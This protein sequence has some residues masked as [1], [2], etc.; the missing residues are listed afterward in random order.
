MDYS[1]TPEHVSH[2]TRRVSLSTNSF[3]ES[4]R[5]QQVLIIGFDTEYQVGEELHNQVLSYQYSAEIL[6]SDQTLEGE[7]WEGIVIPKST[8]L[9]DRLS[10]PEFLS[11]IFSEGISDFPDIVIP[12]NVYLVAHFTRADIPAFSEFNDDRQRRTLNL[13]NIRNSFV[14]MSKTVRVDL[15]DTNDQSPITINVM[16]RDSLHLSP[17]SHKSL[18]SVG[19]ILGIEKIVLSEDPHQNQQIKENMIDLFGR[20]WNLFR[21]YA[22]TD[23]VIC[24]QYT[25]KMIRLYQDRTGK[26]KLPLTL[27]SIGVDLLIK[28]WEDQGIDPL[29]ILGK[30]KHKQ[31]YWSNRKRRY[32]E[33]TTTPFVRKLFWNEDFFTEGY[34]GGRNEQF[35]FGPLPKD[36]WF[37]YDLTSAYPSVMSMIGYPNWSSLRSVRDTNELLTFKPVDL[38]VANVNFEFPETVRFPVLPIRQEGGLIFPKVGNTTTHISEILVAHKLGAKIEL[39]EGRVVS[40][41]RHKLNKD[42]IRPF[43]GFVDY[44]VSKRKSYPKGTLENL[45]WKELVNSSYGKTAQGLRKRRVYDLRDEENKDLA[46]SKITNP[47]FASFITG[48]C[49]ATLSEIM[50]NLPK[51]VEIC[52]VTTDGFLTNATPKQ[53]DEATGGVCGR[54]YR[55]ARKRLM[56]LSSWHHS[57]EPIYEI[58]HMI[59][60]P[61]GWRTRGQATIKPASLRRN[62]YVTKLDDCY[63][64]AKAGIKPPRK[65]EKSVENDYVVKLFFNRTPE[66]TIKTTRH[67]G[68][69]DMYDSGTDLTDF[70]VEKVVSMEFDWKRRPSKV[71]EKSIGID[72]V[73]SSSHLVFETTYWDTVEQYHQTREIWNEYVRS[74]RKCLKT[75]SDFDQFLAFHQSRLV[76]MDGSERYLRREDG[77]L[78]RLRQVVAIAQ[79]LRVAGTHKLKPHALGNKKI[80]PDYKLRAFQLAEF[81]N[82]LGVPC[83]KVDIE[84]DRRKAGK[85]GWVP[86]TVPYTPRTRNVLRKLKRYVFPKLEID[87]FLTKDADFSLIAD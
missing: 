17:A 58:K 51:S 76:L 87:Q 69:R 70:E 72:G 74:D 82:E 52:S 71:Y 68:I 22:M 67:Y 65:M 56:G 39:V 50:N 64:L 75:V 42:E 26:F 2:E 63:V 25:I 62:K 86:H 9:D 13:D 48:F 44:C 37:D 34:H 11:I 12:T 49:R 7:K 15:E 1:V 40:S 31:R 3:V 19:E 24:L 41:K 16:I 61:L 10:I 35:W 30:E 38:V 60:Q 5:S 77:D 73:F 83:T 27:T 6:H 8:S 4:K 45:F 78:K 46:P 21:K 28:F 33:R 81:L 32:V 47:V 14:N 54:Y 59:S 66:T 36:K 18:S 80:F 79:R 53:M 84:N 23:A 29:T 55:D 57:D 85:D 43:L 20:D